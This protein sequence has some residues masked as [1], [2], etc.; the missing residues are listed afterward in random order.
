LIHL[1]N[2]DIFKSLKRFV[3]ESNFHRCVVIQSRFSPNE[4][5][6]KLIDEVYETGRPIFDWVT[7]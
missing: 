5:E 6:K 3:A 4:E 7:Q 2:I 1:L